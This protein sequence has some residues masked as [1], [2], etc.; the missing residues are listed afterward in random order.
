MYPRK[1]VSSIL[2][3][4]N[5]FKT[6]KPKFGTGLGYYCETPIIRVLENHQFW[7]TEILVKQ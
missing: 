4:R 6:V 2:G 3:Y 7:V 5:T 1:M